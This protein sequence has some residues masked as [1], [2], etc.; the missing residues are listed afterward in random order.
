MAMTETAL[1]L[2]LTGLTNLASDSDSP[3]MIR[4]V[5]GRAQGQDSEST[6]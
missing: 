6:V 3:E 5:I 4:V 2:P 1:N